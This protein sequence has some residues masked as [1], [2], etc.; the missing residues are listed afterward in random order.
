MK[1]FTLELNAAKNISYI[2]K[3]FKQN[4][5][6][7]KFS[8]KNSAYAYLYL[9][10]GWSQGVLRLDFLKY[11]NALRWKKIFE[12]PSPTLWVDRCMRLQSFL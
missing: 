8:T 1:K 3:C 9:P 6:G 12:A 11:Y 5:H 10:L 2:E 4:L 7:I